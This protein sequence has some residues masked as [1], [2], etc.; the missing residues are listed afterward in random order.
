MDRGSDKQAP[1]MDDELKRESESFERGAPVESRV[2][3]HRIVE[4]AS[5]APDE[6]GLDEA[7]SRGEVGRFLDPSTFPADRAAILDRARQ[8]GATDTVLNQLDGLP[9]GV[10][11]GSV[12]EVWEHLGRPEG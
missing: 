8:A 4:S 6:G 5:E 9:E 2:E 10:T 11:F 3:E 1:R 12:D 7:R